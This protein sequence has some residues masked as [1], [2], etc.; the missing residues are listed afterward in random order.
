MPPANPFDPLKETDSRLSLTLEVTLDHEE[1]A[2][3]VIRIVPVLPTMTA[4]LLL[5]MLMLFSTSEV[6]DG[7]LSQLL[8]PSVVL[9]IVPASPTTIT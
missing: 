7:L 4:V 6:P 5:I 1:P 2:S 3:V 9:R 8:P